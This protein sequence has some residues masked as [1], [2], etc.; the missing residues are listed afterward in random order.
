[1]NKPI[2]RVIPSDIAFVIKRVAS[3]IRQYSNHRRI[4]ETAAMMVADIPPSQHL[5][6]VRAIF[7][8]TKKMIR[9]TLDPIGGEAGIRGERVFNPL[10]TLDS[11]VGDCDDFAV[12]VGSLLASIGIPVKLRLISKDGLR[13]YDHIYVLAG[14]PPERPTEWVSLDPSNRGITFSLVPEHKSSAPILEVVV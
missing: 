14:L 9:L 3:L 7:R 13:P 11:M 2:Y 5:D 4:R 1:M 12:L 8:K 6:E 10:E